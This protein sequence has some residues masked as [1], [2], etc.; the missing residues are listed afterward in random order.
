MDIKLLQ[1]IAIIFGLS[2]VVLQACHLLKLPSIVGFL[3]TGVL[4][5]PHALGLVAAVHEVEVMAEVGVILL[6][7]A[8][9]LEFSFKEIARL[10]RAVLLGGGL[11]VLVTILV[12]VALVRVFSDLA[13]NR[14]IFIGFL[15]ALSSTAIVLKLYQEKG[16]INSPHGQMILSIL[17]FQDIIVVLMMLFTPMLAGSFESLGPALFSLG[18]KGVLVIG[19]VIVSARYLVPKLLYRIASMRSRETFLLAI[20]TICLLTAWLTSLA[21]LSLGL[22]AFLA[23]LIISESDYSTAALGNITPFRDVFMSLFF[24]SIGML[25][26]FGL[27]FQKPLLVFPLVLAVLSAKT[28]IVFVI[29]L[30]IGLPLR[31]VI[32][33][34]FAISQVGEFSFVLSRVG[35]DYGF[36]AGDRYQLFLAVSVITMGLTPL[37]L[38]L[39]SLLSNKINSLPIPTRMKTG[40]ASTAT[41][42]QSDPEEEFN[43]HLIIIGF[44]LSGLHLARAARKAGI[45]YII[46]EANPDTVRRERNNGE[47]I[48]YGDATHEALLQHAHVQQ[49]RAIVVA[50]NDPVATR[51]ITQLVREMSSSIY[52]IVRTR[53]VVE[54]DHLKKLGADDVIPE[55]YETAVEIFTRVLTHYLVPQQHIERLVSEVRAGGYRMF[56]SL[57]RQITSISGDD[58]Y[59]CEA[60]VKVLQVEE[61]SLISGKTIG[62][63]GLRRNYGITLLVIRRG[64]KTINNPDAEVEIKARDIL[65]LFGPQDKFM[66][67]MALMKTPAGVDHKVD[68]GLVAAQK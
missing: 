26:D 28:L 20:T 44:G 49:A 67:L 7:F 57:S 50:I 66:V 53:L 45:R 51:R 35:V 6:L 33:V 40:F 24:V 32:L 37:M 27:V 17:I 64:E 58:D 3:V 23:G 13:F 31:N 39:A 18:L 2:I 11:Q 42:G 54:V 15:F 16:E 25:L 1:D 29:C 68:S 56:R 48:I 4:L 5:G 43:N 47:S 52:L 22:G 65:V 8:I 38:W 10:K 63:I 14:A 36:L 59:L 62:A 12:T 19:L 34:A 61:D 55:E 30:L 46:I 41:L 21:G 9:G 60:E